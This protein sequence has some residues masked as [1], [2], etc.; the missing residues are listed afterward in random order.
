M[1]SPKEKYKSLMEDILWARAIRPVSMDEEE[2]FSEDL[3]VFW[4]AMNAQE[5]AEVERW[6]RNLNSLVGNEILP[7]VD[8]DVQHDVTVFPRRHV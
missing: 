1:S 5:C 8:V 7:Y 2:R 4:A 6:F 3:D